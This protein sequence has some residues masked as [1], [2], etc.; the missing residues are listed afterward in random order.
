MSMAAGADGN[1]W[2]TEFRGD[3]VGRVSPTGEVSEIPLRDAY[4]IAA[5]PDGGLWIVS[6][7]TIYRLS[8]DGSSRAFRLPDSIRYP[9]EII[10][11][12]D[13][14]LWF[15]IQSRFGAGATPGLGRITTEG[16]I[17]Q[18]SVPGG[19]QTSALSGGPFEDIWY[20][21]GAGRIGW[22]LP[23]VATGTPACINSCRRPITSLT[24]GPDGKL[25]FAAGVAPLEPFDAPGTVGTYAPPPLE[26]K[27]VGDGRLEDGSLRLPVRCPLNPAARR[28]NGKL[29]LSGQGPTVQRRLSLRIGRNRGVSLRLPE[30]SLRRLAARGR[31]VLRAVTSVPDGRE[32][33][34]RIVLH[35]R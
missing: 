2:F 3:K 26:I 8:T 31:L 13:G 17:S 34:R 29:R 16:E 6:A 28:C 20:S 18:V 7:D 23:G 4:R 19:R 24:E 21:N 10:S 27:L 5:G 14:A 9:N 1:L 15:G 33:M 11:G 32:D 35:R 12:P 22:I 30:K 25:W